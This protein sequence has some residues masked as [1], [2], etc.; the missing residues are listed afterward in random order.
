MMDAYNRK[1][2]SLM[3]WS[4]LLGALLGSGYVSHIAH[5]DIEEAYMQ[6]V[7][8]AMEHPI[9]QRDPRLPAA[10]I[11]WWFGGDDTTAHARAI[12]AICSKGVM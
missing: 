9:H 6:G 1:I 11:E 8:N 5:A 10:A 7:H 4:V 12:K 3:A 2:A